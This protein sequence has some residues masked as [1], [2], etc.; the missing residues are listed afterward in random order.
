MKNDVRE[1][2]VTFSVSG[3]CTQTIELTGT[4]YGPST[5]EEALNDGRLVTT[6]QESGD[7]MRMFDDKV[8]GKVVSSDVDAEYSDFIVE[9]IDASI[10]KAKTKNRIICEALKYFRGHR[11]DTKTI[12]W[13]DLDDLIQQF[14]VE[15]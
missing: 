3:T 6:V 2:K 5:I 9:E 15:T 4:E 7:L 12:S 11:E 1:I 8:F 10:T 14:S 13:K